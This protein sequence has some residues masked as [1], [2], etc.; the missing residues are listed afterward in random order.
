MH[1]QITPFFDHTF[2]QLHRDFRNG[3]NTQYCLAATIEKS[4]KWG[5]YEEEAG[6]F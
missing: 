4:N 6:L 5:D 1:D 3:F 2:L